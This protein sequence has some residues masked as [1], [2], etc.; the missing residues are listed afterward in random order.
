MLH[1]YII[2]SLVLT[3]MFLML[4]FGAMFYS[5]ARDIYNYRKML[6]TS[7]FNRRGKK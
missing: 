3:T 1:F 7:K 5:I 6:K 4:L 2:F